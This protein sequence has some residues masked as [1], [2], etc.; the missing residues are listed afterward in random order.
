MKW[1]RSLTWLT[2]MTSA[3]LLVLACGGRSSQR[4]PTG[5]V[6]LTL[7][8]SATEDWSIIGVKVLSIS[9]VPKGGGTPVEVYRESASVPWINLVQLDQLG[10]IIANADVEVGTYSKALVTVS[11]NPGDVQLTSSSDPEVSFALAANTTVPSSEIQ[12][13]E[14]ERDGRQPHGPGQREAG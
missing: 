7:S 1:K 5:T 3:S 2:A 14:C 10:E 6:T 12:G 9:L 4:T 11:A 13:Q 8:D